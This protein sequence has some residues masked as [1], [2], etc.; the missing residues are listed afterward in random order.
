MINLDMIHLN[1]FSFGGKDEPDQR[2]SITS[3]SD[4]GSIQQ[5]IW[6]SGP[7][8]IELK[9]SWYE[10]IFVLE[11]SAHLENLKTNQSFVLNQGDLVD[12]QVGSHWRW[13]IPFHFKKIFNIVELK[14]TRA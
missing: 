10:S 1:D 2:L 14:E 6:E 7:G 3:T 8:E 13:T 5:G 12:F 4:C 11:G 9:F